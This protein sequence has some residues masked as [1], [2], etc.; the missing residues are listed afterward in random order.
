[1]RHQF[2]RLYRPMTATAVAGVTVAMVLAS[3]GSVAASPR[4]TADRA[5]R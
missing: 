3:G 1:M 4:T 5:P 2:S